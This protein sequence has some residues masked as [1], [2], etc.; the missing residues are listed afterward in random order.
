M[1][2]KILYSALFY[3]ANSFVINNIVVKT[4][5]PNTLLSTSLRST[6]L[7]NS[8]DEG[9][10]TNIRFI[11]MAEYKLLPISDLDFTEKISNILQDENEKEKKEKK[12]EEEYIELDAKEVNAIL[13]EKVR[14]RN[15]NDMAKKKFLYWLNILPTQK[16]YE[17]D[18][19]EITHFIEVMNKNEYAFLCTNRE[20]IYYCIVGDVVNETLNI[21]GIFR[22]FLIDDNR[23]T[24]LKI[25]PKLIEYVKN[26]T[27]NIKDVNI[28]TLK[29][30]RYVRYILEEFCTFNE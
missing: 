21:N 27:S 1:K 30:T 23:F 18:K 15:L 16:L 13:F 6:N 29:K 28:N 7:P 4:I 25:K 20:L 2:I 8:P 9:N 10:S 19:E 26:S 17:S 24:F 14:F 12:D 5:L 3:T 22:N 11:S